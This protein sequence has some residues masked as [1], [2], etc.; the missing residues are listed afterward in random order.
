MLVSRKAVLANIGTKFCLRNIE[1]ARGI[2]FS[3]EHTKTQFLIFFSL[4]V[5]LR[6]TLSHM[7]LQL[8]YAVCYM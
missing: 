6:M 7:L 5:S 8:I 3:Y 2:T 1:T 4:S